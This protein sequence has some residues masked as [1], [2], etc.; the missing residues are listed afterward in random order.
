M[1]ACGNSCGNV[2]IFQIPKSHPEN[3]PEKLKP[4]NKQV[5]RYNVTGMHKGAISALEWSKNGMKLFSGDKNGLVILTELDFYMVCFWALM[6]FSYQLLLQHICKSIEILNETYEVVQ[7]SYYQHNLLIST[8]YRSIVCQ[9]QDKWK[10][11][12]VGKKD[13]KV[14][15]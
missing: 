8:T 1:L 13:R 3:L 9:K 14:Y 4:K 12:Q 11:S 5:E 15:V 10:I 2:D 6:Y 7:L